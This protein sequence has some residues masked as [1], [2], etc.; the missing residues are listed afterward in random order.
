MCIRDSPKTLHPVV[1]VPGLADPYLEI[2]TVD[3]KLFDA[4]TNDP[5][6]ALGPRVI[7]SLIHI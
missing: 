4:D 5:V 3:L 2:D 6:L 7:L 1:Y